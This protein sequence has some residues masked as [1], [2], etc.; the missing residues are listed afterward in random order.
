MSRSLS[1]WLHCKWR[2]TN[3]F[4]FFHLV[5]LVLGLKPRFFLGDRQQPLI[6]L[7]QLCLQCVQIC[8]LRLDILIIHQWLLHSRIKGRRNKCP[9]NTTQHNSTHVIW[10]WPLYLLSCASHQWSSW[11][12]WPPT[13]CQRCPWSDLPLSSWTPPHQMQAFLS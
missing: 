11:H 4:L 5:D 12:Q 8:H 3:T 7:L 13:W 9:F 10:C 2:L 6:L 1:L